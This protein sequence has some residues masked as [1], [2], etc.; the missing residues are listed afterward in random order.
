MVSGGKPRALVRIAV[1]ERIVVTTGNKIGPAYSIEVGV[2]VT[3]TLTKSKVD[4]DGV[5]VGHSEN[6]INLPA[7]HQ[8]VQGSTRAHG[9][10]IVKVQVGSVPDMKACQPVVATPIVRIHRTG[11]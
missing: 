8:L 10:V 4:I 1:T 6:T 5:S 7:T 3:G 2:A 11:G 9:Q